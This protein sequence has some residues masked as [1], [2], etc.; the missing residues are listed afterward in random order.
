MFLL[1]MTGSESAFA[2]AKTRTREET[3]KDLARSALSWRGIDLYLEGSLQRHDAMYRKK[4][5]TV[6]LHKATP[7]LQYPAQSG[8]QGGRVFPGSN[9]TSWKGC[10]TK[11]GTREVKVGLAGTFRRIDASGRS[12]SG[13]ALGWRWPVRRAAGRDD[14]G[15]SRR[16]AGGC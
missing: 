16:R 6:V 4:D 2:K 11:A 13:L 1:K 8:R 10:C 15:W 14:R 12:G 3:L 5:G 9:W 7:S